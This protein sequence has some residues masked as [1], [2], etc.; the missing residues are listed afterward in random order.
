MH[1]QQPQVFF[2]A[3]EIAVVVQEFVIV[4]D[5]AG[6][7]Q[8]I[9]GFADGDAFLTQGAIVAGALDG[10]GR[11]GHLNLGKFAE[12]APGRFKA[13]L[14]TKA[15]QYFGQDQVANQHGDFIDHAVEKVGLRI[16]DAVEIVNPDGG[17][18]NK[19]GVPFGQGIA[20]ELRLRRQ[21]TRLRSAPRNDIIS[22]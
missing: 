1:D 17:V 13:G 8:A 7:D 16:F 19:H 21:R 22:L 12:A 15:L 11:A 18:Y 2:V 3:V 10:Q 20:S 9:D 5:A 4:F 6:G 14:V